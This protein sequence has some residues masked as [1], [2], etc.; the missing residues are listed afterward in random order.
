ME[1]TDASRNDLFQHLRETMGDTR[2]S[3]LMAHLPPVGWAD[4]ATKQ[5]LEHHREITDQKLERVYHELA[6]IKASIKPL[7]TKDELK[8]ATADVHTKIANACT[9]MHKA[10]RAQFAAVVATNITLFSLAVA[11]VRWA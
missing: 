7:A 5:D 8:A 3:T 10:G 4:V 1:I 2:A 11:T 6:S 9:E